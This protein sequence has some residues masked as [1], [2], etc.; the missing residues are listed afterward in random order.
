MPPERKFDHDEARALRAAGVA[1]SEIA[2]R[3]G[4][5]K[6]AVS[7]A[8]AN[9][10]PENAKKRSEENPETF[11]E[12]R[13]L[14]A[15]EVWKQFKSLKGVAQIQ[16][17]NAIRELAKQDPD[18]GGDA[19]PEP[20]IADIISGVASMSNVRKLEILVP[21]RDRYLAEVAAIDRVLSAIEAVPA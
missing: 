17:F 4:V 6:G 16:A 3:F 13:D 8:T 11:T 7:Q 9:V 20:L 18:S 19:E 12:M 14:A 15:K 10:A 21:E 5:T 2:D 1:V